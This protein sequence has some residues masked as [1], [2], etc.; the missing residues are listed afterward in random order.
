MLVI[1]PILIDRLHS[2]NLLS[3]IGVYILIVG[4]VHA[5]RGAWPRDNKRA[6]ADVRDPRYEH[7]LGLRDKDLLLSLISTALASGTPTDAD[8]KMKA[9]KYKESVILFVCGVGLCAA[10]FAIHLWPVRW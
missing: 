5:L 1:M 9:S 4:L 6:T 10:S 8:N 3:V 7:Y 2:W